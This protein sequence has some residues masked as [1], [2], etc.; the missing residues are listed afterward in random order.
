LQG[1]ASII[2]GQLGTTLAKMNGQ[3]SIVILRL[4]AAAADSDKSMRAVK[5]EQEPGQAECAKAS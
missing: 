5:G 2:H 4:K 1:D 3:I